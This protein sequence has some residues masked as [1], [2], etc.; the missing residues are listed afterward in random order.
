MCSV[1]PIELHRVEPGLG[2]VAV[3]EVAHLGEVAE[4]LP[5]DRRLRPLGLLER[6]RHAQ[7]AYAVVAGGV[8]HHGP[9]AAADVE[10]PLAGLERELA[11]DEVELRGL[12]LLQRRRRRVVERAGV[13]HRRAQHQLV[14]AVR[15]VV[16]VR[17]DLGIAHH[18]VAQP[19]DGATPAR[20][21]L[22]R[23]RG[24]RAQVGQAE[25]A[26]DRDGLGG[27]RHAELRVVLEEHQRVVGVAGVHTGEVEVEAGVGPR[28]PEV[29]RRGHQVGQPTLGAQVHAHPCVGG[30]G[31]LPSYAVKRSGSPPRT[32]RPNGG[33]D[34]HPSAGLGPRV[35]L[36][37]HRCCTTL[38]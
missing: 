17:D 18:R 33:A 16:V 11:G 12:R 35:E 13:G 25:A 7:C 4:A 21:V 28:Q 5:L 3:V 20:Q 6:E 22:L 24:R 10:Q 38:S 15:D 9:P 36:E 8:A 31:T 19:L 1:R 14:E 37:A 30:T 29:A 32:S 23:R 27:G 34:G 2:D 26:H